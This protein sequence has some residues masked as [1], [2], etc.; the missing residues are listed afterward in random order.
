[1]RGCV[2]IAWTRNYNI[3]FLFSSLLFPFL[4]YPATI[5]SQGVGGEQPRAGRVRDRRGA[6]GQGAARATLRTQENQTRGHDEIVAAGKKTDGLKFYDY[7][8]HN[9]GGKGLKLLK[10]QA[11]YAHIQMSFFRNTDARFCRHFPIFL[12]SFLNTF[13]FRPKS[14]KMWFHLI[15]II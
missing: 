12:Q 6:A 13:T 8:F 1:M 5:S 9:N 14:F 3:Y 2:V 7:I 10:L 11:K 4:L 15:H